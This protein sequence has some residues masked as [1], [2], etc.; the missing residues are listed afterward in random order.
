MLLMTLCALTKCD[1]IPSA[2]IYRLFIDV[3]K[4]FAGARTG[5]AMA[6]KPQQCC[7]EESL[8]AGLRL[9]GFALAWKMPGNL[10]KTLRGRGHNLVLRRFLSTMTGAGEPSFILDGA[11]ERKWTIAFEIPSECCYAIDILA[12]KKG[13]PDGYITASDALIEE[14]L[15]KGGARIAAVLNRVLR[16]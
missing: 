14:Q 7:I 9:P 5:Y 3:G 4:D 13:L 11:I 10:Q 16:D 1:A 15:T 12:M 6:H 8:R 2:L